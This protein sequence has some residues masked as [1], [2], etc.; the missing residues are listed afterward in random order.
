MSNSTLKTYKL[1]AR[2]FPSTTK[3][4]AR[5]TNYSQDVLH[6][7]YEEIE[8]IPCITEREVN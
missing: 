3:R 4:L 6:M 5:E 8:S 7:T 1:P 2:L